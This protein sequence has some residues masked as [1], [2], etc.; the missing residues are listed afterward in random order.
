MRRHEESCTA[1]LARTCR[2]CPDARPD[3]KAHAAIL[4]GPGTWP[5]KMKRLREETENCPC[6]ILA[7]IRQSG[8]LKVGMPEDPASGGECRDPYEGMSWEVPGRGWPTLGFDF[9][10]EKAEYLAQRAKDACEN[11]AYY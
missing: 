4:T 5:E 2:M 8:V 7:A 6:C 10:A 11:I 9:K 3:V 1:N